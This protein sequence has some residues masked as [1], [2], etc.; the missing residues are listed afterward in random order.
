LSQKYLQD[1]KN[2]YWCLWFFPPN[3]KKYLLVLMHVLGESELVVS[4]EGAF[5]A[6]AL[7]VH[8]EHVGGKSL[9]PGRL[10]VTEGAHERLDVGVE[11][12]LQTPI[13]HPGPRAVAARKAL[14]LLLLGWRVAVAGVAV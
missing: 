11:V 4:Q 8:L 3:N 5:V 1:K 14:L 6:R 13:V 10:V 7:V 12:S 2:T 9:G